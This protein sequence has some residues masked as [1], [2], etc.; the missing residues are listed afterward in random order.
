VRSEG[1]SAQR[2]DGDRPLRV[3]QAVHRYL[4]ESGGIET[5][6]YEISRRLGALD[7]EAT[8]LATDRSGLLPKEDLIGGVRVIR[9]RAW[10]KKRDY[11]I[12]PGL[13]RALTREKWDIVHFQGV[14][15]FFAPI[16]ML[17]TAI[18]RIPYVMTFHTGGH[19]STVRSNARGL[20]WR[21]MAP[22]LRRA[23]LLIG[24]SKYESD[25][26]VEKLGLRPGSIPIVRNGGTLPSD[27]R[28]TVTPEDRQPL[29]MSIGRL[30]KYKGH[31]RLIE[32]LPFI[33][34]VRPNATVTILGTG[35]YEAE[36]RELAVK[37]GVEDA[38]EITYIPGADREELAARI[39]GA[40]LV[41]MLSDYEAHPIALME[42]VSLGRPV[43]VSATSGLN[44]LV[45][46]GL[47]V[48]VPLDASPEVTAKYILEQ[49][50]RPL[51]TPGDYELPTWDTCTAQLE[52][53]Y[54]QVA[55]QRRP[56]RS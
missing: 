21:L 7:I 33:R 47:C 18:W 1:S 42:A 24:V 48:S 36:L 46:E 22:L 41:T 16:G 52:K 50:D 8:V 54:R 17:I 23:D 31:H 44:E 3:L 32:A 43:V 51:V 13:F 28:P 56:R 15:T 11:Y 25:Y 53:L 34:E 29:L 2:S 40:D 19:T 4:P 49:L 6:V 45:D 27:V 14:H 5:H 35:P 37:L 20:Q 9:V 26:F 55:K 38:V 30:V 12:P 39:A 10:P